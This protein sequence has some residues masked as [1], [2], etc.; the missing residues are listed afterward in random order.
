VFFLWVSEQTAIIS[1]YSINLPVFI[2]KAENVYCAVRTGP[3]NT[4]DLF[5][6]SRDKAAHTS[7]LV[8]HPTRSSAE[9]EEKVELYI[10]SL[11]GT[12]E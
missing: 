10:Y 12:S 9:A 11:S 7:T 5:R 2:N 8:D 1:I 6:P 3:L 4:T